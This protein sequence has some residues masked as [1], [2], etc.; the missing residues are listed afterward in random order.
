MQQIAVGSGEIALKLI[1]NSSPSLKSDNS[2]LT[3]A[4]KEISLYARHQLKEILSREDHVLIDEEDE[5]SFGY[6]HLER[7]KNIP[8]VWAIDPIDGTRCFANQLP[9]FGFS[10]GLLQNF[11]PLLGVVYFPVLKEM[12]FCDG[13]KSYYVK[14]AF[15]ASEE[16]KTIVP[17]DQKITQQSIFY[18]NDLF[19]QDLDWDYSL[20]RIMMP[21]CAI[22]DL[23][24]PAIGR[25][26][27]S[28][29]K[30]HLWDLAGSWPIFLSAGLSLR[31]LTTGK[32]LK[33]LEKGIF[34]AEGSDIWRVGEYYI[35]SSKNNFNLLKNNIT[36]KKNI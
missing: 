29:F 11:K 26:C 4:D 28:M 34:A 23:C 15:T 27:G 22:A 31:S 14:N 33:S 20:S 30:A 1:Y 32:E 7:L 6:A 19:F 8:F 3:K 16:R 24:W 21:S 36:I 2:V 35:L 12:F 9:T 25:G 5:S 10:L 17:V 13:E 18:V